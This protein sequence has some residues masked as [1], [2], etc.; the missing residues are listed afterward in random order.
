[1]SYLAFKVYF[2]LMMKCTFLH[3]NPDDIL[4]CQEKVFKQAV[5]DTKWEK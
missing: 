2:V 1:M 4:V 3:N 5:K